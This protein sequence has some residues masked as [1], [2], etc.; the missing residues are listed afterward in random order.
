MGGGGQ[1][2]GP[3]GDSLRQRGGRGPQDGGSFRIFLNHAR[4][5]EDLGGVGLTPLPYILWK[6]PTNRPNAFLGSGFLP[7]KAYVTLDVEFILVFRKGGPRR[8]PRG[9][10]RRLAS[11][12]TRSERDEWFSQIWEV[13]GER[14]ARPDLGRGTAAFPAEIP[15]RL[16]RMFSVLGHTVPDPFLGTGTTSAVAAELGRNSVGYEIDDR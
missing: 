11:S 3:R 15:R 5:A 13:R 6:K 14:Q 16:I 2:A 1:G 8:F 9:D 7:P 4:V 12:Y 10:G